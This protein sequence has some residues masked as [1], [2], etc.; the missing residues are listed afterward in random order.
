MT[1][2]YKELLKSATKNAERRLSGKPTPERVALKS[3]FSKLGISMPDPPPLSKKE[4]E[5]LVRFI[6]LAKEQ[7]K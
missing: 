7:M 6:E 1:H 3:A 4:R 5:D 2:D